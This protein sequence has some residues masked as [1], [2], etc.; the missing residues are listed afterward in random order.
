MLLPSFILDAH[1]ASEPFDS[2]RCAL[3]CLTEAVPLSNLR[4]SKLQIVKRLEWLV[5][6][7]S[8]CAHSSLPIMPC[9]H[10]LVLM[11]THMNHKGK[12]CTHSHTKLQTWVYSVTDKQSHLPTFHTQIL[13]SVYIPMLNYHNSESLMNDKPS[14]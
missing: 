10:L 14:L 4:G 5:Q 6:M 12:I 2:I 11:C 7:Q 1:P 3:R 13:V 9:I 8:M